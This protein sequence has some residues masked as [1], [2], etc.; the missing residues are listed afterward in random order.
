MQFDLNEIGKKTIMTGW[1]CGREVQIKNRNAL[2]ACAAAS[3][4]SQPIYGTVQWY[5]SNQAGVFRH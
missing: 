3:L 1:C 4:H 2:R 5:E